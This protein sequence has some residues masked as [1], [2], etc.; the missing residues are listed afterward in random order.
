MVVSIAV[1][2]SLTDFVRMVGGMPP[3]GDHQRS[4]NTQR[5][6]N[7]AVEET[8]WPFSSFAGV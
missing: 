3:R 1:Y 8:G 6:G 2:S 5:T 7:V 4:G